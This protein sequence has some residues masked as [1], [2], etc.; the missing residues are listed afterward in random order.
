MT[1][2]SFKLLG[3]GVIVI[4]LF[5][6]EFTLKNKDFSLSLT[7]KIKTKNLPSMFCTKRCA[8]TRIRQTRL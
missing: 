2:N 8:L 3:P 1:V 7:F 6:V 4:K 5:C